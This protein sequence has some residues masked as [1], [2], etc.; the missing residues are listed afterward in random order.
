[1]KLKLTDAISR[2]SAN[3]IRDA[4]LRMKPRF[5][6]AQ[7]IDPTNKYRLTA[8]R[9][10]KDDVQ[11]GGG[12]FDGDSLSDYIAASVTL[13]CIDGWGFLGRAIGAYIE[14]D[15]AGA[16]HMAYYAELRA[17]KSFLA[18]EGLGIFHQHHISI[19]GSGSCDYFSGPTHQ[20]TWDA[21]QSWADEPGNGTRLLSL[22][23]VAGIDFKDWLDASSNGSTSIA[24]TIIASAWLKEWSLDLNYFV[25]D[26]DVRNSSSYSPQGIG[27]GIGTPSIDDTLRSITTLWE[28]LEPSSTE[29]FRELDYHL[30]KKALN[31]IYSLK[32]GA[33]GYKTFI[34]DVLGK[35][36]QPGGKWLQDFLTKP[37]S[38]GDI[39]V[40]H[41]AQKQASTIDPLPIICRALLLLRVA[42]AATEKLLRDV[43][44]SV[45]EIE[46]WWSELG[47]RT[48]LWRPGEEPGDM[49]ELWEDVFV[50]L[51]DT[52]I[53]LDKNTP[54]ASLAEAKSSPA[55]PLMRLQEMHRA[56]LWGIGL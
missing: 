32:V 23:S 28:S 19:D 45:S 35:L 5:P 11:K 51:D 50:F 12:V 47:V 24:T 3:A 42:S 55:L 44:I 10:I 14:G 52:D 18:S 53:W 1:M 7:W 38:S 31:R 36:G 21:L 2:A 15:F 6:N 48:G 17:A 4:A 40:F 41:H 8:S 39:F 29:R 27:G 9:T 49:T 34:K 37:T 26:R 30:L 22:F 56:G 54:G 43:S 20:K 16:C 25:A 46:F 13:H 33:P